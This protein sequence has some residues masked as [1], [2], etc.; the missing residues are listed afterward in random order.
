MRAEMLPWYAISGRFVLKRSRK[1]VESNRSDQVSNVARRAPHRDDLGSLLKS[2]WVQSVL[3]ATVVLTV[4]GATARA[5]RLNLAAGAKTNAGA[6]TGTVVAPLLPL[7]VLASESVEEAWRRRAVE[8]EGQRFADMYIQRGYSLTPQLAMTIHEAALK[9]DIDPEIAFGLVRA[10]SSFRNHA[11]SPVGA[12]G[13][14]QLMPRTAA[15]IEPGVSRAELRNPQR[16]LEIGFKYLRYLL[17]KYDG[18]EDLALLAYNRGPGTVDRALRQG[19][20]PDNGYADFVRGKANHGHTLFTSSSRTS[21]T[22]STAARK[23]AAAKKAPAKKTPAKKA[24]AK[25]PA[26]K[27]PARAR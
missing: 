12:V 9:H 27:K 14:T 10:E 25:R 11:T 16:N 20:N 15:W 8:R 21:A 1:K 26:P 3:A 7:N 19:A 22:R 23:P 2:R 6:E 18:N 5:D 4:V 17:D 24:P 13:L